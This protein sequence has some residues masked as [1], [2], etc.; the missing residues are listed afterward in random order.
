[1]SIEAIGPNSYAVKKTATTDLEHNLGNITGFVTTIFSDATVLVPDQ[2]FGGRSATRLNEFPKEP[3]DTEQKQSDG[4]SYSGAAQNNMRHGKGTLFFERK[5]GTATGRTFV[6]EFAQDKMLKGTFVF[7]IDG[8]NQQYVYTGEFT[9]GWLSGK[10][11][12]HLPDGEP[13]KG[14]VR[15]GLFK[16]ISR[17]NQDVQIQLPQFF[18]GKIVPD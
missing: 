6:G 2:G 9:D 7:S 5:E 10:G 16:G 4:V 14:E 15:N 12:L 18:N 3:S 1:M 17:K 13:I 11:V 8:S